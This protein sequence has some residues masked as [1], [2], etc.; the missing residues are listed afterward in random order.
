MCFIW[1]HELCH[2]INLTWMLSEKIRVKD[3][4]L[5]TWRPKA[6]PCAPGKTVFSGQMP[7]S[8]ESLAAVCPHKGR[9]FAARC[10]KPFLSKGLLCRDKLF[11]FLES[12]PWL[13]YQ[14]PEVKF[15]PLYSEI[16]VCF[17]LSPGVFFL[18]FEFFFLAPF[19]ILKL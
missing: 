8:L 4:T 5:R 7:A 2:L 9:E 19:L 10:Q 16:H 6:F 3:E 13:H 14:V 1:I 18:L 12:S 17:S 15:M 11:I